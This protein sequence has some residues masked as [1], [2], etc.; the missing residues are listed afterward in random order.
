[1]IDRRAFLA[2]AAYSTIT[3]PAGHFDGPV[4]RPEDYGARGDGV[5]NDSDA[6]S[7]VSAQ[8]NAQG[9]GTV[10]LSP[11]RTY[12]VG[13]QRVGRSSTFLS[14]ALLEF[15]S[16][17]S[18]LTLVGNGARLKSAH[19][20]RFGSFDHFT[21]RPVNRPLPNTDESVKVAPYTGMIVVRGCR[22]RVV[23]SDIELDGNVSQMTIGGRWGDAGWQIPGSGLLLSDNLEQELVENLF[24]HHH[25]LDGAMISGDPR[26]LSRSHFKRLVC[27]HNGRQGLSFVGGRNYDFEDC[28]FSFTG[29]SIISSAPGAGLD[30]EAEDNKQIRSIHFSNCKFVDNVGA[31]MGADTGDSA[32][33]AFSDCLFVGS[34][35]WAAWPRKPRFRFERC[36]FAG[37]VVHPFPSN[38]RLLAAKFLNCKFIDDP[39]LSTKGQLYFGNG[40]EGPVVNMDESNNVS[41]SGCRFD[42]RH[43]GVLPWSW[44]ATYQNCMMSQISKTPAMTKG[45]YLGRTVIRGP[46]ELYGSMILGTV[47]LNGKTL[48]RGPV[49]NDFK[50][51]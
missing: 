51:W 15:H 25:P 3:R 27:Y 22:G 40:E 32:D 33:V 47:I 44:R 45:K 18:S 19:G 24:S 34:T 17:R 37:A 10:V 38:D 6:F 29:R 4:L 43:H 48:A 2:I 1:V 20:L 7:A 5:H 21:G 30:I 11:G 12:I 9:G 50:P 49:G 23:I 39:M 36:T 16:L 8:I 31:G 14:Q 41:F 13:R 42:L 26:R 46:V 35:N 28:E